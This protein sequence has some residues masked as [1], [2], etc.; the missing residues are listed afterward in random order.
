MKITFLHLRKGLEIWYII[1]DIT[2]LHLY[3]GCKH[4]FNCILINRG[5]TLWNLS[6]YEE[7]W[8][9]LLEIYDLLFNFWHN[10]SASA[11]SVLCLLVPYR[12]AIFFFF[13]VFGVLRA[14]LDLVSF[15]WCFYDML[16]SCL[17]VYLCF[18]YSMFDTM[19][20]FS[21]FGSCIGE[22]F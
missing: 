21:L 19:F 15:W 9:K 4:S 18:G 8:N 2:A 13:S 16:H 20:S 10:C 3:G 11:P 5:P 14:K 1:F 6:A 22:N 7:R 17:C 12:N